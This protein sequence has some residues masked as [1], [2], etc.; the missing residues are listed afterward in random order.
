MNS[1]NPPG[2]DEI[3]DEIVSFY[4]KLP[5]AV[6]VW[7]LKVLKVLTHS[8]NPP[9]NDEVF[10]EMLVGCYQSSGLTA[11]GARHI[12]DTWYGLTLRECVPACKN[13]GYRY[14]ALVVSFFPS[15][16]VILYPPAKCFLVFVIVN[17]ITN[18]TKCN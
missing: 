11:A 1:V 2:D 15:V 16:T 8:V 3:F 12:V 17:C 7:I 14:A 6:G 9:G 13:L 18:L 10:D 5:V 4:M